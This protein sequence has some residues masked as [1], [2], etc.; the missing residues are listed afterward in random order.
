MKEPARLEATEAELT[1]LTQRL[2]ERSLKPEDYELLN[3]VIDTVCFLSHAVQRKTTSIQRL[4]RM[5]FGASTE[6]T[7]MVL[8]RDCVRRPSSDAPLCRLKRKGHG[9]RA[10][11]TYWGAKTVAVPH[12]QFKA[13]DACP[14]CTQG[15]LYDTG[16]P[17]VLLH[18]H[19]QPVIAGTRFELEKLRCALCG[20]LFSATAPAEAGE[21]KYNA[22]VAS[23][24]AVMRYGYGM[25]MNPRPVATGLRGAAAGGHPVGAA[26]RPCPGT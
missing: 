2:K 10:A 7:A 8:K 5:I 3:A 9:R 16:R 6:K 21:E 13:A 15:K 1:A 11:E 26:A 14:D 17:A 20:K 12:E 19:A 23:M 24:L 25:P 18:L 4:L 22:N